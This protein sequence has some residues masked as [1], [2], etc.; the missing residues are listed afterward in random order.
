MVKLHHP[1]MAAAAVSVAGAFVAL[2]AVSAGASTAAPSVGH[3][4]HHA[5]PSHPARPMTSVNRNCGD[6]HTRGN[7]WACLEIGQN[8]WYTRVTD[9]IVHSQ[10]TV[11][12]CLH[13]NGLSDE[14]TPFEVIAPGHTESATYAYQ[15]PG[16]YCAVVWRLNPDGSHSL[17][18]DGQC[19]TMG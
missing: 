12:I 13:K 10:R 4:A 9:K 17:V 6:G 5:R 3:H 18:D 16:R 14:C 19:I 15:G 8:P 11:Q 7:E 1:A 2:P